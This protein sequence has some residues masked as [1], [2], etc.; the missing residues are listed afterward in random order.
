MPLSF[1]GFVAF[2]NDSVCPEPRSLID[3]MGMIKAPPQ[4]VIGKHQS[5]DD[6]KS[7]VCSPRLYKCELQLDCTFLVLIGILKTVPNIH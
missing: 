1:N 4:R 7:A 2:G 5:G 6:C 3:K